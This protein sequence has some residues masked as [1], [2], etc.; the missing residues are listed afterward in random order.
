[1]YRIH[2]KE[3]YK[4][5]I[6][7]RKKFGWGPKKISFYLSKKGIT[8]TEGAI[9]GWIYKKRKPFKEVIIK[10]IPKKSKKLTEEK[11]YL[12][13]VLCGDGYLT[14][15]YRIGLGVTDEDFNE[16]FRRCIKEVYN[17]EKNKL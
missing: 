9:G 3:E 10:K 15:G 11:A 2:S 8:A 5:A 6:K 4:A 12:L 13:G 17:R 14:T 16:E 7:L 1:M